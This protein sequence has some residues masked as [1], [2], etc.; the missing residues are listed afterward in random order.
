M[1]GFEKRD[2]GASLGE[3]VRWFASTQR[4]GSPLGG[5]ADLK[6][7]PWFPRHLQQAT[8]S[9]PSASGD[10]GHIAHSENPNCAG[11]RSLCDCRAWLTDSLCNWRD[12]E[13]LRAALISTIHL[14][15]SFS[16]LVLAFQLFIL[17]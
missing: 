12:C 17:I 1:K 6:E 5:F 14:Q 13:T 10:G 11:V 15:D 9:R 16:K 4:G 7:L 3:A 2:F 8:G